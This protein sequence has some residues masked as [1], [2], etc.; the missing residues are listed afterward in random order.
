MMSILPFDETD[1][2]KSLAQ[3][4]QAASFLVVAS[5]AQDADMQELYE[6]I[7]RDILINVGIIRNAVSEMRVQVNSAR[8]QL[9]EALSKALE[10]ARK[11][12]FSL[13]ERIEREINERGRV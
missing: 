13:L 1:L 10:E 7:P 6:R 4:E 3:L 5:S 11:G 9:G 2:G 12:N 8:S